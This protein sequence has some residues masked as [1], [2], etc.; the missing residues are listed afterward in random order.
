MRTIPP[1]RLYV[2][3]IRNDPAPVTHFG[4]RIVNAMP[5]GTDEATYYELAADYIRTALSAKGMFETPEGTTPDMIIEVDFGMEAPMILMG[6][7]YNIGWTGDNASALR[8]DE[9]VYDKY[10]R[11]TA[12]ETKEAAG[13]R[14]PRELWSIYV[15]NTDEE[16]NLPRYVLLMVSAAMDMIAE[17]SANRRSLVLTIKDERVV[18][19]QKGM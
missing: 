18:F 10:L 7:S 4:Y 3:A 1:A 17:R 6:D 16:T 2:E 9:I 15:T 19:I 12:R 13:S 11:I 8:V 14:P 5:P